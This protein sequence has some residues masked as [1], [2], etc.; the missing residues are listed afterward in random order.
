MVTYCTDKCEYITVKGE[1]KTLAAKV[2][3]D[4]KQFVSRIVDTHMVGMSWA[5]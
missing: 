2:A 4:V 5:N 3:M 1:K